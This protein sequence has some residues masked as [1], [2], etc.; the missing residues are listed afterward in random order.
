M[1][2]EEGKETEVEEPKPN[3]VQGESADNDPSG[4]AEHAVDYSMVME[5]LSAI[6]TNQSALV[7]KVQAL[8]DAQSVL[9]DAGAVVR[10]VPAENIV[11]TNGNED[12]FIPLE[13]L[14]FSI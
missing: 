3:E 13:E 4:A 14:D 2:N 8:T 11:S 1:E 6:E 9:V 7:Q 5:K 10:E 12:A